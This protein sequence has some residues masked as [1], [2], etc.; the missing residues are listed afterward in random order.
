M[1]LKDLS[2]VSPQVT[3][4]EE[5]INGDYI[6]YSKNILSVIEPSYSEIIPA[7]LLRRM[8]KAVRMGIGAALPLIERNEKINGIVMGT[9][10]GGLENCINFLNQIIEYDE[11]VLTP[12][13]FVQSTPNALAGQLAL[14]SKNTG[15]NVT[16]VN[17]PLAFENAI[18][19]AMMFLEGASNKTSLLLGAVEEISNYNY[20]I[21]LIAGRYKLENIA[22]NDLI[23]SQTNGSICGEGATM[24]IVSND[25]NDALAKIINL[26]Q[27]NFPNQIDLEQ[28]LNQFL[29]ENDLIP[30]DIDLLIL[31]NNGDV[32]FDSWYVLLRSCFPANMEYVYY[33]NFVGE[34]RTNSAFALFFATQLLNGRFHN[35]KGIQ[36]NFR[37]TPKTI[38]IYNQFEGIHHS[39]ILVQSPEPE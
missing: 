2:S 18:L 25:A 15:Y 1:Y 26:K 33:K 27:I 28:L 14:M 34:F 7:S 21:D 29:I 30:D 24:F 23:T 10:N 8:G 6:I 5:F 4:T 22:N 20:N 17:G 3:Y 37:N 9:A 13:H 38:L 39:F 32:Q 31:G 19:D 35:H 12:T 11:G 36:G 16:H